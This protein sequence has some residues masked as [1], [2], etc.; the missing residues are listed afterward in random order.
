MGREHPMKTNKMESGP[1]HKGGQALQ[2]FQGRHDD[3]GGPIAIRRFELQDDL[4]GRGGAQPFVPQGRPSDIATEA[5]EGRP[6]MG[7][8]GH[9]GMQAKALATDTALGWVWPLWVGAGERLIFPRPDF[10]ACSR[11]ERNAVGASRCVQRRQGRIAI[12]VG[13]VGDP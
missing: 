6:L 13:Q 10:P 3:M 12:G 2:E 1:G 9:V 11:S 5:F 7:P 8:A 4:A